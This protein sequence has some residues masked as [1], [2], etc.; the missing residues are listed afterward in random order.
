MN[1]YVIVTSFVRDAQRIDV[2][3]NIETDDEL[4][5][6]VNKVNEEE[7]VE[8]DGYIYRWLDIDNMYEFVGIVLAETEDEALECI[9]EKY[10]MP[11]VILEAILVDE[12]PKKELRIKNSGIVLKIN[13]IDHAVDTIMR[14]YDLLN[15]CID[16][17]FEEFNFVGL[18]NIEI[19]NIRTKAM[20]KVKHNS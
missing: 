1:K 10:R 2:P 16:E 4:Y 11:K 8:K 13:N 18:T 12:E 20:D 6:F 14:I 15:L 5:E 9:S 19:E 17:L 7:G 3:D